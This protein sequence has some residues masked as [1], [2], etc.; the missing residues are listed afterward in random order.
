ML[1]F[2]PFQAKFS[3]RINKINS[4]NAGRIN[5]PFSSFPSRQPGLYS[6]NYESPI[7]EGANI[8]RIRF[9]GSGGG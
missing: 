3:V 9:V 7:D 6:L 1:I 4:R 8:L 2:D 5:I